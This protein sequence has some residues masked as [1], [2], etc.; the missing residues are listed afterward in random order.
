MHGVPLR[1]LIRYREPPAPTLTPCL[2]IFSLSSFLQNLPLLSLHIFTSTHNTF[3]FYTQSLSSLAIHRTLVVSYT[4]DHSQTRLF[5]S[6][7]LLQSCPITRVTP[8]RSSTRAHQNGM[9]YTDDKSHQHINITLRFSQSRC[10]HTLSLPSSPPAS[11]GSS[12]LRRSTQVPSTMPQNVRSLLLL[13]GVVRSNTL[14]PNGALISN[15]RVPYSAS[16]SQEPQDSRKRILAHQYVYAPTCSSRSSSLL[17]VQPQSTLDYSCVCSNGQQPNASEYSQTIPYYECTTAATD[18]VNNCNS[19]DSSCQSACRTAH[20]CGAQNPMRVNTSTVS[21]T[22]AAATSSGAS[23][24]ADS[25][26]KGGYTGFGGSSK[27][28]GTS[29]ATHQAQAL[30][31]GFGRM[32]GLATVLACVCGGFMLM[33]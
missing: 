27:A 24:T 18:C 2:P 29:A 16:R 32:Y 12:V 19:A 30:A 33:L 15:H 25:T 8:H 1:Y 13:H 14:Q 21:S 28:T 31:L 23:A 20:P 11:L 5:V 26:A 4:R 6:L 7:V 22:M 9:K 10:I 3:R 17:I